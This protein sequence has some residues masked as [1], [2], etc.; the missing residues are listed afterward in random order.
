MR[1]N[2]LANVHPPDRDSGSGFIAKSSEKKE[3]NRTA[4][5]VRPRPFHE[6]RRTRPVEESWHEA[7]DVLNRLLVGYEKINE[8]VSAAEEKYRLLFEEA[9]VGIFQIN[10]A[11]RP[12][13]VNRAM[14]QIH[15][16][17]SPEQLLAEVS[18]VGRQL[19]VNHNLPSEWKRLVAAR[20]VAWGIKAEGR[21]RDGTKKWIS[22][23]IR[24]VRNLRGKVTHF[25]GTAEDITDR[26]EAEERIQFLAYYDTLTGLP[27]RTMFSMQLA[28]SLAAARGTIARLPF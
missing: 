1:P 28:D 4:E 6:R 23:N 7:L 17:E 3:A 19:L 22:L 27:N 15:G 5:G 13:S 9:L 20:G 11:G 8:Q 18:D 12:I 10:V 26:K 2:S 14:A 21:C 16:F 25:E 24:A